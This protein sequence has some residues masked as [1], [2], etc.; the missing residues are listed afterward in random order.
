MLRPPPSEPTVHSFIWK[1]NVRRRDVRNQ[2]HTVVRAPESV[3]VTEQ[4]KCFYEEDNRRT[5]SRTYLFCSL[6]RRRQMYVSPRSWQQTLPANRCDKP[7]YRTVKK[8]WRRGFN[9]KLQVNI[10][11]VPLC[12]ADTRSVLTQRKSLL[13]VFVHYLRQLGMSECDAGTRRFQEQLSNVNPSTFIDFKAD[14]IWP[15][16]Q[17]AGQ[18]LA[19]LFQTCHLIFRFQFI[20]A[21]CIFRNSLGVVAVAARRTVVCAAVGISSADRTQGTEARGRDTRTAVTGVPGRVTEHLPAF[22]SG[23]PVLHR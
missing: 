17:P 19:L 1:P 6:F 13:I 11:R 8:H 16:P 9:R 5:P 2:P 7:L 15:V 14:S 18:Q 21:S 20:N 4:W 23:A 10:N 3:P 22:E 12:R